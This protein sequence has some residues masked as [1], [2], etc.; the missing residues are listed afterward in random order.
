MLGGGAIPRILGRLLEH[1]VPWVASPASFG[2]LAVA[3]HG[4]SKH[5][6]GA[7]PVQRSSLRH[8]YSLACSNLAC[9]LRAGLR[10]HA[11]CRRLDWPKNTVTVSIPFEAQA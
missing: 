4:G 2:F 3:G 9:H 7:T 8:R 11:T 1:V 10:G 6:A 5:D